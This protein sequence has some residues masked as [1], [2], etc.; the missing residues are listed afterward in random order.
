MIEK[1]DTLVEKKTES[2][3][4][5]V[6]VM[7]MMEALIA[8]NA[9]KAAEDRVFKESM[10]EEIS[11]LQ[12]SNAVLVGQAAE[13]RIIREKMIEKDA[14]L[15]QEIA[16]LKAE[17]VARDVARKEANRDYM[18]DQKTYIYPMQCIYRRI[19]VTTMREYLVRV[20]QQ[21]PDRDIHGL[22]MWQ[23]FILKISN[24]H[25][26][27]E[28]TGFSKSRILHLNDAV[29]RGKEA[30]NE[31]AHSASRREDL[32]AAVQAIRSP[33]MKASFEA[34]YNHVVVTLNLIPFNE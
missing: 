6:N 31:C 28:L 18:H 5:C 30:D 34:F 16:E 29:S 21:Q 32:L 10:R 19:L 7:K 11:V 12:K 27:S 24:R 23:D 9:T 13:D 1:L 8:Q 17:N 20:T 26:V 25:D 22:P 14:F 4:S 3:S 15:E 33:E 2:C